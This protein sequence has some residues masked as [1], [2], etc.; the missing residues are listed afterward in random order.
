MRGRY[1]LIALAALAGCDHGALFRPAGYGSDMPFTAGT[2]TRLTFNP[3]VDRMPA[4]L[5][6]ESG[7]LYSF[8]RLDRPDRDRCLGLLPAT[9]G[10]RA[11]ELCNRAPAADDSTDVW[12]WPTVSPGGRL[13]YVRQSF[14]LA[15]LNS[16]EIALGSLPAPEVGPNIRS[17]PQVLPS[18]SAARLRQLSWLGDSALI[19]VAL[20]APASLLPVRPIAVVHVDLTG[21]QPAFAMVPGTDSVSSAAVGERSDVVYYTRAGD[22]RVYR[23]ALAGD[24]IVY[25]FAVAGVPTAVQVAGSRLVAI[26]TN[27]FNVVNLR[28]VNLSDGTNSVVPT[29]GLQLLELALSRSGRHL[30]VGAQAGGNVD[31]WLFELP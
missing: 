6:D 12:E 24:S 26:V 31:L 15:R 8:E 19:Y 28:V 22:T 18:G 5:P 1:W 27:Q 17:L 7:I 4:W 10:S 29:A 13:A 11:R 14:W 9:G 20:S 16:E 30:V 25:D 3:G 21:A 23:R 2:P